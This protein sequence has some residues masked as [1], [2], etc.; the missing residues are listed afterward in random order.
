VAKQEAFEEKSR[1]KNQF[2]SLDEDEVDFLDS[3]LESTRAQEA[4]VKKETA[5]QLE[6]FRRQR[7]QAEKAL[8]GATSLELAGEEEDTE[9]W[10]APARKR[11][12]EKQK[13][14]LLPKKRKPSESADPATK[15]T[16][17]AQ[18]SQKQE[19]GSPSTIGL[20]QKKPTPTQPTKTQTEPVAKPA[21]KPLVSLGLGYYSSDSE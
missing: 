5:D 9:D 4:A 7:E 19:N 15:D 3:V 13:G 6:A 8:L 17:K 12:R 20:D 18:V 1:L 2:R 14:S 16:Q 10:S 21:P 11:R